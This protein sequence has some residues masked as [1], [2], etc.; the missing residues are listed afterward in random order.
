[1]Q[2]SEEEEEEE[3]EGRGGGGGKKEIQYTHSIQF[4]DVGMLQMNKAEAKRYLEENIAIIFM[5]ISSSH[6][7]R[8]IIF[9]SSSTQ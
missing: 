6:S 5:I 1:M 8:Y 4:A 7:Y 3:E 2:C 9:S